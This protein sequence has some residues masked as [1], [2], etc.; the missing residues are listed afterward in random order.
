M[1]HDLGPLSREE[2]D[3]IR[4]L[5]DPK[6]LHHDASLMAELMVHALG[7]DDARE[8]PASLVWLGNRICDALDRLGEH[9]PDKKTH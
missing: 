1:P 3:V 5:R 9:L 8:F 2:I 7:N 6:T 4:D